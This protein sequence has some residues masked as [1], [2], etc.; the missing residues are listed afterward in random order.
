MILMIQIVVIFVIIKRLEHRM[1]SLA[2]LVKGRLWPRRFP[3]MNKL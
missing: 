3:I 1:R 2:N